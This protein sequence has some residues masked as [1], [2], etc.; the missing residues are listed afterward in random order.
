MYKTRVANYDFPMKKINS[1]ENKIRKLI[2]E[3]KT[4]RNI[5]MYVKDPIGMIDC[6]V[7]LDNI[8]GNE[9]IKNNI[10][11][12]I[13][14]LISEIREGKTNKNMLNTL[15]YGPP[16]TG[17]TTIAIIMAKIWKC[18]G[19]LGR[20]EIDI[21]DLLLANGKDKLELYVL[22]AAGIIDIGVKFIFLISGYLDKLS[23]KI[24]IVLVLITAI[25]LYLILIYT[26]SYL[27][28]IINNQ[29]G[30][31]YK[32]VSREDFVDMYVGHTDK[33]TI[34]LLKRNLG[35]VLIIDE[36]YSLFTDE[37]DCFGAEALTALN[38]FLSE[39]P[40]R[41]FVIMAGY[42]NLLQN[43]VFKIQPGLPRR[44]MWHFECPGY[45]WKELY[46][47][48]EY[49][50]HKEGWKIKSDEIEYIQKMF[51]KNATIF[52]SYGGDI[53]KL[54]FFSK[55]DHNEKNGP[56]MLLDFFNIKNGMLSLESNNNL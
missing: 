27:K 53:E 31:P 8:I 35:K 40:G 5:S 26:W 29:E 52:K 3:I 13:K 1:E 34:A 33:K 14:H 19:F 46:R 54:I 17:K 49:H 23:I 43:G 45:D 42:K 32:I 9:D 55:L 18:L 2:D 36:A 48:F 37:R 47:I 38:R 10:Y 21:L 6:L 51:E 16:G 56:R 4:D 25:I 30:E 20:T 7:E 24:K 39:N 28:E 50:I 44:F 41:I 22:L 12:Q 11:K 15:I